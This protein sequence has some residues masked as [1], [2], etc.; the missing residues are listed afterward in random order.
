[1]MGA[2]QPRSC[3]TCVDPHSELRQFLFCETVASRHAM[4][5]S[6]C[7]LQQSECFL[8]DAAEK[9]AS[10]GGWLLTKERTGTMHIC[11]GMVSFH[12]IFV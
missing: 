11:K 6:S 2:A 10:F 1:M 3:G 8:L 4:Y 12:G 5:Y 7:S 9:I